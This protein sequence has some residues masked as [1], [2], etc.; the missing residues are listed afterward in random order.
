[1]LK[2]MEKMNRKYDL[3]DRLIEFASRVIEMAEGLPETVAGR[4]LGRQLI[5][6]GT[7]SALG[8]GEA[9]GAESRADFIHKM[10][11]GLKELRETMINIKIIRKRKYVADARLD[12][13]LQENNELIAI[14]VRSISTAQSNQ[15]KP[16][17]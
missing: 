17:K 16:K 5:R 14:F 3:E 7:A 15:L 9:Q 13:L 2:K 6:S 1:M 10:K 11:I 4:H 8:Y 12:S